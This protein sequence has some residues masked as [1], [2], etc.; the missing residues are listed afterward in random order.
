MIEVAGQRCTFEEL[1]AVNDRLLLAGLRERAARVEAERLAAERLVAERVAILAQIADGVVLVD[2][3]GCLTFVNDAA[4]WLDDALLPGTA[5]ASHA[6]VGHFLTPDGRPYPLAYRPIVRALRGEAVIGAE[7]RVV[8]TDGTEVTVRI[9]A[10][11]LTDGDGR[12][13]GAVVILRDITAEHELERSQVMPDFLVGDLSIQFRR[14]RVLLC[15]QPVKLTPLEYR[16]LCILVRNAGR[17]L[18]M[19]VLLD[20]LWPGQEYATREHLKV[21]ICRLRAKIELPGGTRYIET[22]RGLGYRFA[23]PEPHLA[24]RVSPPRV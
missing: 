9:S 3:A 10:T 19:H 12:L 18:P 14:Q 1:R 16:L 22:V 5:V 7:A 6:G 2:P 11:P 21:Y 4:R 15:G 23:R 13:A 24:C 8:R 20:R 17:V